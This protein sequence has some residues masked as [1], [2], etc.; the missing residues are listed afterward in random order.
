MGT[1]PNFLVNSTTLIPMYKN[2]KNPKMLCHSSG[3]TV[4]NSFSS[5]LVLQNELES[6][7]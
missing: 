7:F 3:F 2:S 5:N 6:E 1:K 4:L